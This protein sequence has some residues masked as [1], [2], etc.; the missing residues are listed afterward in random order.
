MNVNDLH[1]FLLHRW[2]GPCAP[3]GSAWLGLPEHW[4][5]I[6]WREQGCFWHTGVLTLKR[7][8]HKPFPSYA[9]KQGLIDIDVKVYD[10]VDVDVDV[11]FDVLLKIG[12]TFEAWFFHEDDFL[13]ALVA[14]VCCASGK[15]SFLQRAG[16]LRADDR[17]ATRPW[18]AQALTW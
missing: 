2:H 4:E 6:H 15:V 8:L 12:R 7:Y 1:N 18:P 10:G 17:R 9:V 14:W 13:K 5:Q 16:L 11:E 3:V